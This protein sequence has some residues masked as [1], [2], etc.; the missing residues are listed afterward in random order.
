MENELV[1]SDRSIKE[2]LDSGRIIVN[3]LGE[4][5]IQPASLDIRLD[6]EFRVFRNHRDSFIDIRS[7]MESLTEIETIDDDQAF[8]LHPT[9]FVLG[10]T[11]ELVELPNDIVARVE[12][13]SSLGRLGLLVHATA[14]YVDPGWQGKLTMELSNVSN[15]PIKLYYNMKIGQLSFFELSTPSDNPY[16]SGAIKSKYQNQEGPTASKGYSDYE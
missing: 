8:V 15:L 14:G 16:G 6:R 10:S 1:L 12:G 5:A 9:E 3:P 2:A 13:K 4:N 11:I 7:P